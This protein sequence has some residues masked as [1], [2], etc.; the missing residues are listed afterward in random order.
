MLQLLL[1]FIAVLAPVPPQDDLPL[2][3][4]WTV[5]LDA[6]KEGT[7]IR[8]VYAVDDLLLVE[9]AR[10]RVTALD[11]A[12][13]VARWV[14]QL[15]GAL[16]ETPG[17]AARHVTLATRSRI[18]VVDE[19]SGARIFDRLLSTETAAAPVAGEYLVYEPSLF[20][21]TLFT[22]RLDD[23][24]LAW[25]YRIQS[26]FY[27]QA[28]YVPEVEESVLVVPCTDGVLRAIPATLD[29]P[30]GLRWSLDIGQ[31]VGLLVQ[32]GTLVFVAS[33]RRSLLAI[34]TASGAIKWKAGVDA[35]PLSGP[36]LVEDLA[37]VG[38]SEGLVAVNVA[39]GLKAWTTEDAE[40]PLAGV[41]G[42]V[43]CRRPSGRILGRR[44]ADGSPLEVP[45]GPRVLSSGPYL[46]D[47]SDGRRV[48]AA[49]TTV[50][51]RSSVN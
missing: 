28:L 24:Q 27:G 12:T 17:I 7:G 34:D 18:T 42:L 9:D 43:I 48:S 11:R 44:T 37:L 13:G 16:A 47:W 40:I 50:K 19:E 33:Q 49:R 41:P 10:H 30:E 31:P 35:R 23:G 21:S 39:T 32:R 20:E 26:D 25:R 15:N 45:V 14:V 29:M 3:H 5:G 4:V 2:E 8:D 6:W 51:T 38:T 36:I 46:A 22:R 1:V